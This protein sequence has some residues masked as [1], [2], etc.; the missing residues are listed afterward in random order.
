MYKIIFS[1]FKNFEMGLIYIIYSVMFKWLEKDDIGWIIFIL[2]I[3]FWVVL[4][5][6]D[7]YKCWYLIRI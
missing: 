5:G 3:L 2:E 7:L 6:F 4:V 1:L